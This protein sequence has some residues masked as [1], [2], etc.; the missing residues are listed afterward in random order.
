VGKRGSRS[1]KRPSVHER[2]AHKHAE[3]EEY[4]KRRARII[5]NS[6]IVA[7]IWTVG[8]IL[9]YGYGILPYPYGYFIGIQ[10]FLLLGFGCLAYLVMLWNRRCPV[11]RETFWMLYFYVPL[12]MFVMSSVAF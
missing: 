8:N 4:H 5:S 3:S 10:F 2:R 1:G 9:A 6:I 7:A 12:S 11:Y